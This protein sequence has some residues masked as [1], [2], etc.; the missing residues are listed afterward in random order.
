MMVILTGVRWYLIVLLI[1]IFLIIRMSSIFSCAFWP[2]VCLLWKNVY[3]DLLIF[4]LGFFLSTL[5]NFV[6]NIYLG[7]TVNSGNKYEF[8][9]SLLWFPCRRKWGNKVQVG[10]ENTWK[11]KMEKGIGEE[12][13]YEMEGMEQERSQQGAKYRNVLIP[14]G[15]SYSELPLSLKPLNPFSLVLTSIC[16]PSPLFKISPRYQ[17]IT[18]LHLFYKGTWIISS[19]GYYK[20]CC[21][22]YCYICFSVN[23]NKDFWWVET[24]KDAIVE[25]Q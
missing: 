20:C 4:W 21:Y 14:L 24:L 9:N 12:E 11:S 7:F 15:Y 22:E 6:V 16:A 18:K 23:T 25:S 17:R 8:R 13:V 3:L 19:F 5:L 2:S 10:V 1:C